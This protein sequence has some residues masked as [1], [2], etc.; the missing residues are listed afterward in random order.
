V[1]ITIL[2][3]FRDPSG[4][5]S[6]AAEAAA[7]QPAQRLPA[8]R[9]RRLHRA[10]RDRLLEHAPDVFDQITAYAAGTP[11]NVVNPGALE[12]RPQEGAR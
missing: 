7:D 6:A 10:G 2:D 12:R 4:A 3:D 9:H 1:K 11:T 8:R 5:A